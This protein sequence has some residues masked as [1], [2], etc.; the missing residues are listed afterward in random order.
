MKFSM[1]H[2]S[3]S[4]PTSNLFSTL[5]DLCSPALGSPAAVKRDTR[6]LD[7]IKAFLAGTAILNHLELARDLAKEIGYGKREEFRFYSTLRYQIGKVQN[8]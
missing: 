8:R 5:N 2:V 4:F 6:T 3:A 1:R 7:R